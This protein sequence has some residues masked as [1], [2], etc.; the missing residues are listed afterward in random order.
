MA[1]RLTIKI[2]L[3]AGHRQTEVAELTSVS[4]RSVRRVDREPAPSTLDD[5]AARVVR[6]IGRPS[7]VS[8][9][10]DKVASL[11]AAEPSLPSTEVLRRM[12]TEG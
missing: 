7:K 1:K 6:R 5:A 10:R 12:K 9:V 4:E 2:L 3:D 11:M 8:V